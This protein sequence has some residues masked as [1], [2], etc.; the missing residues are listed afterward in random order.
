MHLAANTKLSDEGGVAF[1]I[2]P[3]DVLQKAASAANELQEATAG[4]EVFFVDLQVLG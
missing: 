2:A 3:C 1:R 4:S